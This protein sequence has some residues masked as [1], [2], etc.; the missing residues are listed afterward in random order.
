MQGEGLSNEIDGDASD[1][2]DDAA[3]PLLLQV[4]TS[5]DSLTANEYEPPSEHLGNELRE[6]S[7]DHR[8]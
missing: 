8:V 5:S 1:I 6:T 3:H 4:V 2:L 7:K